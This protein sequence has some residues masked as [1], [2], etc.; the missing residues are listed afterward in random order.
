MKEQ[1][2]KRAR[3]VA[4]KTTVAKSEPVL[5]NI[6]VNDTIAEEIRQEMEAVD[7]GGDAALEHIKNFEELFGIVKQSSLPVNLQAKTLGE[8]FSLAVPVNTDGET[9]IIMYVKAIVD[10]LLRSCGSK[11]GSIELIEKTIENNPEFKRCVALTI[12]KVACSI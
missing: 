11:P 9:Y 8:M 10:G 2:P 6:C 1:K 12:L 4:K 5:K 7:T 3:T